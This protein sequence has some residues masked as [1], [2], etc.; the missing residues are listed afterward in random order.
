MTARKDDQ[1]VLKALAPSGLIVPQA[2]IHV[3]AIRSLWRTHH[4]SN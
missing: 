4:A 3:R 2:A 1:K